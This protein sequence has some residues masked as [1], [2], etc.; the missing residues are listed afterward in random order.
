MGGSLSSDDIEFINQKLRERF[1]YKRERKYDVADTMRDELCEQFGILIDDRDKE[2]SALPSIEEDKEEFSNDI[3]DS[4]DN[5]SNESFEE[6]P[7]PEEEEENND[8]TDELGEEEL[9]KLTVVVLK[10]KLR[11]AGLPV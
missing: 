1:Q 9:S 6:E 5:V 10:E 3:L 4:E 8:S 2:W 11:E 7:F